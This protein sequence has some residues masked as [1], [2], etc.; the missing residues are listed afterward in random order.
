MKKNNFSVLY[1]FPQIG[2]GSVYPSPLTLGP[3][4]NFYGTTRNDDVNEGTV[5][6]ISPTGAFA[7]IHTFQG[8]S[9][10]GAYPS[11]GGTYVGNAIGLTLGSDG[12]L[13]G[14]TNSGGVNSAG[15]VYQVTTS[16]AVTVLYSFPE[17]NCPCTGVTEANGNFYGQTNVGGT[18]DEGT[19]YQL[20]PDGTYTTIHNFDASADSAEYPAFPLTLGSDGNLYSASPSFTG[21]YGPESLYRITP[22]GTYTDLYNGFA[23]PAGSGCSQPTLG[24]FVQSPL[25]QSTDGQFYGATLWGGNEGNGEAFRLKIRGAEAF[26]RP[27][28]RAAK[29][30][31]WIG[32]LGQGFAKAKNVS[33]GGKTA[34]FRVVSDTWLEARVPLDA[35]TGRIE[36]KTAAGELR[37]NSDFSPLH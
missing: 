27:S 31:Q 6:Q 4:G 23:V 3:D 34:A 10:D 24:C 7:T 21:G 17:N 37:S 18:S 29:P 36:V 8:G 32:M 28:V 19:I 35:T 26:V 9:D 2:G 15:T 30:G 16:G 22:A 20:T 33:F 25:Y 13:Y 11:S 1:S 5:F 12:N 14:T